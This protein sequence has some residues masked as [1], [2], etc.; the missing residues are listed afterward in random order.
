[1]SSTVMVDRQPQRRDRRRPRQ[2]RRRARSIAGTTVLLSALAVAAT[3]ID[4]ASASTGRDRSPLVSA[5][6]S[7]APQTAQQAADLG[8]VNAAALDVEQSIAVVDRVTGELVAVHEGDRVFNAE[9][10]LKLFTAAF[11]LLEANG[12]PDVELAELLRTMIVLSD[13][14]IQ[15]SLWDVDIIPTIA[16]RYGLPNT[17]NGPNPS[18]GT[19]GSDLI[20]ATDQAYFLYRVSQDPLVGP[21][22]MNWMA[23]TAAAGADGFN[24]AFGFNA[25]GGDHGSKQGWSDPGWSPANLHSVGW[26]DRYF[27]A[28]LQ[29]SPTATYATMRATA[30]HTATL[31]GGVPERFPVVNALRESVGSW[32]ESADLAAFGHSVAKVL[33]HNDVVSLFGVGRLAAE[34]VRGDDKRC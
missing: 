12:T 28:I 27:A 33:R 20:T 22:L 4:P 15:S 10:I 8:R 31:I 32:S 7:A 34:L 3:G 9:S 23:S 18:D 1:M 2:F 17:T 26:T 16:Y 11:Y 24:Q 14:G 29:T 13:N 6:L 19:W 5:A 30:T 25:L 21:L